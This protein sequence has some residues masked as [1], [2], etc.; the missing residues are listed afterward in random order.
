MKH[1]GRTPD[2]ANVMAPPPLVYA[3]AVLAGISLHHWAWPLSIPLDSVTADY[4]GW[5][6][7]LAGMGLKL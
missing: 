5:T 2:H 6:I 3:V 7:M 1:A 4:V